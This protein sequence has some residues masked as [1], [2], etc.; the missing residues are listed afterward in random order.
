MTVEPAVQNLVC[1]ALLDAL[2]AGFRTGAY[3]QRPATYRRQAPTVPEMIEDAASGGAVSLWCTEQ[4]KTVVAT[5]QQQNELR[6]YVMVV[7]AADASDQER[8]GIELLAD[9]ETM[10][11]STN[12]WRVSVPATGRDVV[13]N[14]RVLGSEVLN[15][16]VLREVAGGDVQ[17]LATYATKLGDPRREPA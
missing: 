14:V 16:N 5:R 12:A 7:A 1:D 6:I 13:V 3:S 2:R 15:A 10:I 17:L 9:V 11:A 4:Q 8:V